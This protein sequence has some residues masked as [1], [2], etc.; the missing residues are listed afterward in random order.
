M[1]HVAGVTVIRNVGTG[2]L[3]DRVRQTVEVLDARV[4]LRGRRRRLGRVYRMVRQAGGAGGEELQVLVVDE[5]RRQRVE[6]RER[7]CVG[8]ERRRRR[9]GILVELRERHRQRGRA[10][11]LRRRQEGRVERLARVGQRSGAEGEA[12]RIDR[13]LE[14]ELLGGVLVRAR[15]AVGGDD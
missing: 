2:D 8:V 4:R 5:H 9:R 1:D 10:A 6:L 11:Y 14:Q 3:E 12:E 13:V 15:R 7:E